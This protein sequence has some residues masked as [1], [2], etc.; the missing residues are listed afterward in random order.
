ML[1]YK[2]SLQAN[3]TSPHNL[4]FD[5]YGNQVIFGLLFWVVPSRADINV[6]NHNKI[7]RR[8]SKS[9]QEPNLQL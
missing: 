8:L 6:S 1:C 3:T 5:A 4:N 7:L 2:K 9:T